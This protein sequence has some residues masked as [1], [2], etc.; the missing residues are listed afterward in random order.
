V[1]DEFLNFRAHVER[2]VTKARPRLNII[3]IFCHKSWNLS[4]ETLK[5]IYEALIGSLFVY[6]FFA[7]ARIADT[8]LERLQNKALMT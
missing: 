3:K 5:G 4:H 7:V 1:F 2:L 6:S 8:N